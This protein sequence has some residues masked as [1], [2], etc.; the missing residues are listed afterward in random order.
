MPLHTHDPAVH[1][2]P[3]EQLEGDVATSPRVQADL[4]ADREPVRVFPSEGGSDRDEDGPALNWFNYFLAWITG[5]VAGFLVGVLTGNI[6]FTIG[7][8]I[9]VPLLVLYAQEEI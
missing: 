9:I 1:A 6:V 4:P 5:A 3:P 8:S 2:G 7:T